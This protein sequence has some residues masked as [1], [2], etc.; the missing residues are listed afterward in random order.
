MNFQYIWLVTICTNN[1]H[2]QKNMNK[3]K[4]LITLTFFVQFSLVFAGTIKTDNLERE[5]EL[6]KGKN[7]AMTENV[8]KKFFKFQNM[9]TDEKYAEA[10]KG[11]EKL[12]NKRLNPYEKATLHKF[13]G[14]LDSAEG[15]HINATNHFQEAID[16]NI[17]PNKDHFALMLKKASI[18]IEYGEYQ[19]GI[20]AL[21]NYYNSTDTIQ[22]KTLVIEA[23]A[24]YHLGN[25]NKAIDL[26]KQ[27]IALSETHQ[28]KWNLALYKIYEETAQLDEASKVLETLKTINPNSKYY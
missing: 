19:K 14:H 7:I 17:L 21:Q 20:N 13:I 25:H 4:T 12:S 8:Y 23:D 2:E 18:F 16:T 15:N 28:E 3:I 26:L 6:I 11:L 1:K 5:H 9:I 24:Y 22:D 10:R 27:A